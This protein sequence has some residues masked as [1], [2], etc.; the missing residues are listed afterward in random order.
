MNSPERLQESSS[1]TNNNNNIEEEEE[2]KRSSSSSFVYLFL[3]FCIALVFS[4]CFL[5]LV[6]FSLVVLAVIVSNLSIS[7]PISVPCQCKIVSSSVDIRSAKVCELG[8]L[9]YKAK[10]VFYPSEKKKFRCRYDYYWASV[11]EVEYTDHSGHPHIA[12]AEAPN[13]ALPPDCRPTFNAAWMAKDI[14]K[15]NETYDCWYT[16][17]I[18]K[19]NLYYDEIFNCQADHPSTIEMLKRYLILSTDMLTSWLSPTGVRGK[20][21]YIRLETIAGAVTGFLTSLLTI[22]LG[23]ILYLLKTRVAGMS[24]VRRMQPLTIYLVRLKRACFLVAYFSFV[25][26]LAIQYW[27]K[28][29][30]MDIFGAHT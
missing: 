11:F 16:L 7:Y 17:G 8:L 9:N 20:K 27:E 24:R 5:A 23:R 30:L 28:L 15:V 19:L 22:A 10:H 12:F 18:S 26:W 2:V 21:R 29:G 6:A 3:R 14:F 4:I 1:T 25:S 13:E